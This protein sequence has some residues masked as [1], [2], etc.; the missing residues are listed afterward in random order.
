MKFANLMKRWHFK[1]LE[2]LKPGICITNLVSVAPIVFEIE[3]LIKTVSTGSNK[4]N[5]VVAR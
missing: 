1:I 2:N 5:N 3:V 4:S